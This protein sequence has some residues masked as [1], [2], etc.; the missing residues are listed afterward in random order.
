MPLLLGHADTKSRPSGFTASGGPQS[1][2]QCRFAQRTGRAIG[3]FWK[4]RDLT[5]TKAGPN[6]RNYL[7]SLAW[8]IM[9]YE[10]LGVSLVFG[11]GSCRIRIVNC[12]RG[13]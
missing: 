12:R 9:F 6:P 4:S 2:W 11:F 5:C 13:A 10:N 8:D 7:P 3:H 1:T